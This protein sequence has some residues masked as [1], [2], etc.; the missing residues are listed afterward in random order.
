MTEKIHLKFL[1]ESTRSELIPSWLS[2][3]QV[4]HHLYRGTFPENRSSDKFIFKE[5][6]FE[7][8]DPVGITIIGYGGIHE[9]NWISRSGELR[10]LIGSPEFWNK[11]FGKAAIIKMLGYAFSALNL[12][13]VWLGVNSENCQAVR[14]YFNT[15]FR[16]EGI[17]RQEFYK[18]GRYI[19]IV[20]M[21][22]LRIEW[23]ALNK[24]STSEKDCN[25]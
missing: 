21:S 17:L 3:E 22:I 4:T 12:N 11:G 16:Q 9:I 15:G 25:V 14:L 23:K 6:E 13:R 5:V 19:D 8:F 10:I 1:S 7:F 20:R 24:D 18:H 2:N